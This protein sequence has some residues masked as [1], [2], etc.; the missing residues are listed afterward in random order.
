MHDTPP[1][2]YDDLEEVAARE[3]TRELNEELQRQLKLQRDIGPAVTSQVAFKVTV[4]RTVA[5]LIDIA[6]LVAV[7]RLITLV[8]GSYLARFHENGWWIGVLVALA[9]FSFFDS[10]L[11][12]GRT[13]G[14]RIMGIHVEH[15]SGGTL[16]AFDALLRTAPFALIAA[17]LFVGRNSDPSSPIILGLELFGIVI[18]L[19]I[20]IF[21]LFHPQHR[22]GI[23]LLLD[24]VVVRSEEQYDLASM[25]IQQPLIL[26][27]IISALFCT[28]FITWRST[29]ASSVT[30][31]FLARSWY[32]LDS[33][34]NIEH[35]RLRIGRY[36]FGIGNPRTLFVS[37]FTDNFFE[38][39]EKGYLASF[40]KRLNE[41]L[42]VK[43]PLPA[44]IRRV[45][46]TFRG[47]YSIGI[48]QDIE[49]KSFTFNDPHKLQGGPPVHI[50]STPGT[51]QADQ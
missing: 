1:Q 8:A 5:F 46:L 19:S 13:L 12:G 17:V 41:D 16:S 32:L 23:D 30:Q 47:G 35:P 34:P 22:T 20:L 42:V 43:G 29:I 3:K 14:K 15:I 31:H 45:E 7:G 44:H 40:A 38:L 50:R 33:Q 25:S 49:R 39:K 11:G 10:G 51:S 21:G 4:R 24:A 2:Q 6:L 48:W 9:Y 27:L 18:A 37:V 28:G 36:P 26:F